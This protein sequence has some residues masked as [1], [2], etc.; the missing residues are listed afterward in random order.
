MVWSGVEIYVAHWSQHP[1][2]GDEAW[3]VAEWGTEGDQALVY[4]THWYDRELPEP[5]EV[6]G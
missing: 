6:K 1:V 4:P 5:P 2:T 3:L